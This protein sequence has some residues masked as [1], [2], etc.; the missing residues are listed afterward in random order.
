MDQFP[1]PAEE[2]TKIWEAWFDRIT[3]GSHPVYLTPMAL[4]GLKATF[5]EVYAELTTASG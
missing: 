5:D 3:G 4:A 2:L 1:H